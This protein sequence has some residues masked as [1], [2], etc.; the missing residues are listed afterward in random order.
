MRHRHTQQWNRREFLAGLT[1]AGTAGL[2][3]L[4]R[5]PVT[6]E[7][8][9]ETTSIK[10]HKMAGICIAPQYVAE[11]FLYAEGFTDVQYVEVE[12]TELT[13]AIHRRLAYGEIDIGM[14]FVPPFIIQ[15]DAG[16]PIAMLGGVHVGCFELFGTE[17]VRAI[18]DLKG[19][20]VAVPAL[21]GSHHLFVASMAQYIGLDPRQDIDWI[22]HPPA[23]SVQLLANGKIDALVGFPPVPQE[24]RAKR[25]GHVV[26]NSAVDRPWSQYFCCI[27]TGNREFVRDHPLATKRVLRAILKAT[28]VCALEPERAAQRIVEKGFT[29]RY[30][31]ALQTMRE[32]PYNRWRE[33]DPEDTVRFYALRLHEI[34]MIQSTPQK[35]IAQGTD[36]R[37]FN[38]LKKELKG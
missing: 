11:E 31:Y 32:T 10:L 37:F 36:W 9:P 33:Y 20:T 28:D 6:A 22:I 16:V 38:E 30:D 8:P 3:G 34:G 14:A 21:R 18:R 19:K 5:K 4:H 35:I 24:L 27:V 26:V 25:I 7:P 2:V 17:R 15:V 1:L 13:R 29:T 23:E 12:L